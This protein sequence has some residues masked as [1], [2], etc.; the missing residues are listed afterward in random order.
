MNLAD[1]AIHT[2]LARRGKAG[3]HLVSRSPGVSDAEAAALATWSPSH[4]SLTVDDENR[5]SVQ[6]HP[7][8]GG[9][10]ALARTCQGRPEY[11]G[12]GGW[13]VYTHALLIEVDTL[14]RS[15]FRPF[16]IY[17]DALALGYPYYRPEPPAVLPRVALPT[18]T[19][20]REAAGWSA[21]ARALGLPVFDGLLVQLGAG[22]DVVI[23]HGG[24]RDVLAESL[25][26]RLEPDT[27]LATSFATSLLPSAVRPFRLQVVAPSRDGP[28]RT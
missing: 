1:Q 24:R 4:D 6:F 13:Q 7:L 19:P 17:R 18:F 9:R 20:K 11:S 8:P 25:L 27:L 10:F 15:G 12:R 21:D 22:Q 2:S 23:A 28:K 3:Y 5:V 14:R 16:R 26:D